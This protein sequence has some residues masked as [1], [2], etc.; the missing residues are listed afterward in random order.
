MSVAR[1]KACERGAIFILQSGT[2]ALARATIGM[3][4]YG[5]ASR[6]AT[7]YH[8][9]MGDNTAILDPQCQSCRAIRGEIS[10]TNAPRILETPHWIV[11]HGHPTEILGWLVVVLNRHCPAIHDLTA[12]EFAAFSDVLGRVT[13][14]LHAV[15]GTEKEYVVQFA[16]ATGHAHVHFHVIARLPDW[17][18]TLRGVRVFSANGSKAIHL[19]PSAVT[20]PLAH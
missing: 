1:V 12:G 7:H 6:V 4:R 16:E 8:H 15:L 17:P 11:E 10:L 3:R 14:A 20:T 5:F 13:R 9:R 19:L 2:Q 18:D